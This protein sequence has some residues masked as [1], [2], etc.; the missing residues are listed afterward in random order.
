MTQKQLLDKYEQL[1]KTNYDKVS[2]REILTD[3]KSLPT[4]ISADVLPEVDD[5]GL[6]EYYLCKN[7]D[8]YFIA[9]YSKDFGGWCSS[10]EKVT[11][12]HYRVLP[13]M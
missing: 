2:I 9:F 8:D 4:W 6:S 12:T 10:M 13:K 1:D 5:D 11:V 3:L 7:G